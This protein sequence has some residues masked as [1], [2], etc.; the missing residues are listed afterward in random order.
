MDR[1]IVLG[2]MHMCPV[3]FEGILAVFDLKD[4]VRQSAD[5]KSQCLVDNRS[6]HFVFEVVLLDLQLYLRK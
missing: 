3:L 6:L 4:F 5:V 2:W 1:W